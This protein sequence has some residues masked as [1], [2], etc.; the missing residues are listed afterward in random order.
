MVTGANGF[1]PA[2]MV[3]TLLYLNE[4]HAAGIRVLA[5]VRDTARAAARFA[6]YA[7][8][9]DLRFQTQDLGLPLP[10]AL[11]ADVI[12]H[13]ASQASPKFY[14]P[15]PVGTL[16]PNVIGTANLLDLARDCSAGHFLFF[17]SGEVY[18]QPAEPA[19]LIGET[20]RGYVDPTAVR[21]C[22]AESKRM[23]ETMCVAWHHQFGVP[24]RIVRPFHTYGPGM[25][26][27]DGRVFA[28]FVADIVQGRDILLQSDGSA[29]RAF[30]YLADATVGFFT[31]LLKGKVAEAYNIGNS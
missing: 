10:P 13:A 11:S 9:D 25:R 5:L 27:D 2:Y 29:L 6:A 8:R 30:C 23:A 18:G 24:V 28:D 20:A 7:G 26:L 14:D 12:I 17:S 4:T 31:V 15:D 1:L 3:E 21:S 16:K 19:G 22:Y